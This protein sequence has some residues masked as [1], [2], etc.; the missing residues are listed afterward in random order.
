MS[1]ALAYWV[2]MLIILLGGG[3]YYR[4]QPNMLGGGFVVWLLFLIVGWAVF[5]SPIK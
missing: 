4:G 3:W 2:I 5:G 1:L